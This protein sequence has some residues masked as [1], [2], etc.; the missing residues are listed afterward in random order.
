MIRYLLFVLI[1]LLLI[2]SV[3][4]YKFIYVSE[5]MNNVTEGKIVLYSAPW[6]SHCE[7]FKPKWNKFKEDNKNKINNLDIKTVDCQTENELCNNE[8][9]EFIPSIIMYKNGD[10]KVYEGEKDIEQLKKWILSN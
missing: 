4:Y 7:Q 6:C 2:V 8:K 9:I 3:F 10:K 1:F 5:N